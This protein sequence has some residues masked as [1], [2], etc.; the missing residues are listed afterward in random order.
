[1]LVYQ[2][3]PRLICPRAAKHYLYVN[4]HPKKKKKTQ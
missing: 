1:M 2:N 3:P 4:S